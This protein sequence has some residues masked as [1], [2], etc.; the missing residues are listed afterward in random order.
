MSIKTFIVFL[1]LS[2]GCYLTNHELINKRMPNIVTGDCR[3]NT[4][5]PVP[6]HPLEITLSLTPP[7]IRDFRKEGSI[8]RD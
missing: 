7:V 6:L 4:V 5:V 1:Q 3:R 8:S 2:M